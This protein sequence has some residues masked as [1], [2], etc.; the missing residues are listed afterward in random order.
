MKHFSIKADTQRKLKYE[1]I[2]KCLLISFPCNFGKHGH[3]ERKIFTQNSS[4]L[5]IYVYKISVLYEHFFISYKRTKIS[6]HISA[7][8]TRV[9]T[10]TEIF[11]LL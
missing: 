4:Y 10:E 7:K 8:T 9:F 1:K 6:G 5:L 2:K 3:K 11:V